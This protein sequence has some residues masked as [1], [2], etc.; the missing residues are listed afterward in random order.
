MKG[1]FRRFARLRVSEAEVDAMLEAARADIVRVLDLALDDAADLARIYAKHGLPAPEAPQH[2]SPEVEAVCARIAMLGTVLAEALRSGHGSS[3]LGEMYLGS[4]QLFLAELRE[5][6]LAR[7]LEA[8]DAHRLLGSASHNLRQAEQVL[9]TQQQ[10]PL[11][12][13]VSRRIAELHDLAADLSGQMDAVR[14]D[15]MRL[16][17]QSDD[18]ALVPAGR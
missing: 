15:V 17:D 2:G 5:G 6:L 1:L 11:A 9:R 13:A 12:E 8:G 18:M 7:H 14:R 10:G 16:F 3:L 4:A